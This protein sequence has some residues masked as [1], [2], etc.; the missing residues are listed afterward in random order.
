MLGLMRKHARSWLIKVALFAIVIVFI[1]WGG[2]SY[3]ERKAR[4]VAVVNG[5]YI[6]VREYQN[7]YNNLVEEMRRRYG[8]NYSPQLA[9]A[10]NLKE[11]ALDRLI[12]RRLLL[13][14][15]D[16]LD[17]TVTEKQLQR[18]IQLY[19]AF[20][21]NGQFDP[22]RYHRTL[23]SL[24]LA[25]Q[26]FEASQRQDLL[27][28]KVERFITRTAKVLDAEVRSFYHHTRDEVNL[29]YVQ[30]DPEKFTDQV[31]VNDETLGEYFSEHREA[32]RLPARRNFVY[33]RFAPQDYL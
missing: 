20:Q 27:I 28:D 9:K 4:R 10:L 19:P 29:T 33:V 23:S 3:T 5:S 11:Q 32:Y 15:A 16:R 26:D 18:A 25:P 13:K 14:Q 31:Q 22:Q 12:N 1:F 24:R 6:T 21:T 2:Y 17:L 7:A 8:E 30:A